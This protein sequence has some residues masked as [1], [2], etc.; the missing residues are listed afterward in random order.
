MCGWIGFFGPFYSPFSRRKTV[1]SGAHFV[2]DMTDAP[3][4]DPAPAGKP[5]RFAPTGMAEFRWYLSGYGL[6]FVGFGIN[7]VLF[8]YLVVVHLGESATRVT[9]A[10]TLMMVPMLVLVMFGGAIA[11]RSELKSHLMRMQLMSAVP[12][13]LLAL[14]IGFEWLT[15]PIMIVYGLITASL[16]AFTM[17]ARDSFLTNVT[18]RTKKIEIPRAVAMATGIQFA[19]QLCG[20][21]L[22]GQ[23][24]ILG[25]ITLLIIFS[26]SHCMAALCTMPLRPMEIKKRDNSLPKETF[27]SQFAGGFKE[28]WG[29]EKL[30]PIIIHGFLLALFGHGNMGVVVP[31]II[32]DIYHGG[33]LE[34]SLFNFS[35]VVGTMLIAF[36]LSVLPPIQHQGRMLIFS[37]SGGIIS[38]TLLHFQPQIY[39]LYFITV[40]WGLAAGIRMSLGRAILQESASPSHRARILA[41]F[42]VGMLGG[43]PIGTIMSGILVNLVGPLNALLVGPVGMGAGCIG[44]L[45]FTRIWHIERTART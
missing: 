34:L 19:C 44:L 21:A 14:T 38:L 29:S 24:K 23:A 42:A 33:A 9:I 12:P 25:P 7:Q 13:L 30:R 15:Y 2:F 37:M 27:L 32:R 40:F 11:D 28:V 5:S 8:Q 31:L 4:Q 16:F 10:Q 39:L 1:Y 45:L 43:A 35:F 18:E 3:S 20:I 22:T 26:I 36:T 41:V 17:P 6:Y